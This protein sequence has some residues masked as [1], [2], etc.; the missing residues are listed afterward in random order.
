MD[1]IFNGLE[2]KLAS[3]IEWIAAASVGLF[4][5]FGFW[6]WSHNGD[7][8]AAHAMINGIPICF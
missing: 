1:N 5:A 6:L 2:E 7:S 4:A 8:I 3:G